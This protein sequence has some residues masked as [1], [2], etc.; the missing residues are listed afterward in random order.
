[1]TNE[2]GVLPKN[3]APIVEAEGQ[4]T[5]KLCGVLHQVQAVRALRQQPLNLEASYWVKI[6]TSAGI[7]R[8]SLNY[9]NYS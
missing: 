6:H 1:M 7:L 8:G 4:V 3:R 9:L 5:S 2:R